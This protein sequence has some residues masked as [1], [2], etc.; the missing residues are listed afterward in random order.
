MPV[1][2]IVCDS[3]NEMR[4]W[5]VDVSIFPQGAR[6]PRPHFHRPN[7]RCLPDMNFMSGSSLFIFQ[8]AFVDFSHRRGAKLWVA[9]DCVLPFF[10][11]DG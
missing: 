11:F 2:S 1:L 3:S 7:F 8:A 4:F 9:S 10:F 5:L 6:K